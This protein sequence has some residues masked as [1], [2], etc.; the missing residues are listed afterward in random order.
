MENGK[1]PQE[2]QLEALLQEAR[3]FKPSEEFRR[4]AN[5]GDPGIYERADRDLEGFWGEESKRLDWIEPWTKVLEWNAPWA[6]WFVGGKLNVAANCVDRHAASARRNK[7][8]IIWEGEPGDSRVLTYGM[9]QREVNRFAN[10]LRSLGVQKGDRVAIYMGMVPELA[11]AMLACA[12]IGA[13]HSV[14]FGGFSAESLRERINDATAK[15]LITADGGWR[16]GNV[17]PLKANADA[18]LKDTPSIEKVIVL[19]RIGKQSNASMQSPRDVTWEDLVKNAS[20]ECDAEPM[21]SEDMLYILYTSGTT[22]KPKGVV[23]TTAGYLTGVA[24]THHY[25]FDIKENDVYWCTADIGWIPLYL[26]FARFDFQVPTRGSSA[27]RSDVANAK[28]VN[29]KTNKDTRLSMGSPSLVNY[30]DCD[31]ALLKPSSRAARPVA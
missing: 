27:A 21:D 31:R 30:M 8:A 7:A 10:G 1:A 29:A 4:Q 9:L 2:E 14:V 20:D 22:G 13:P 28:R 19:E 15:V 23:H 16:R 18:A 24:A 17:V 26:D 25:I 12:K 11:I 3:L 6:K 5:A